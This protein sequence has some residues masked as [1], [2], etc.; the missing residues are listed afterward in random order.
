M[1]T[2]VRAS[3]GMCY[4]L[5]FILLVSASF[6]LLDRKFLQVSVSLLKLRVGAFRAIAKTRLS[7]L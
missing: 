6:S 2:G 5:W 1:K 7:S 4:E 3:C